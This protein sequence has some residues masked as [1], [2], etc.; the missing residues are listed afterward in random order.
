[1]GL[2][3]VVTGVILDAVAG[4][5]R[6]SEETA[7]GSGAD[8]QVCRASLR[9]D[10]EKSNTLAIAGDVTWIAGSAITVTGAVLLL[11]AYVGGDA[12]PE[13]APAASGA[14]AGRFAPKPLLVPVLGPGQLGLGLVG[15]F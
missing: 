10:I 1:V 13:A 15:R 5:S 12:E 14:A 7:C 3:A 4:G 6:P 2:A 8:G 11:T 9:D